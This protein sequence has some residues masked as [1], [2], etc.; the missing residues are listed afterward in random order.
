MVC[1][2]DIEIKLRKAHLIKSHQ[3]HSIKSEVHLPI[4][5]PKHPSTIGT[6]RCQCLFFHDLR[7]AEVRCWLRLGIGNQLNQHLSKNDGRFFSNAWVSKRM[8]WQFFGG[9]GIF[10]RVCWCCEAFSFLHILGWLR[11]TGH[12]PE[13]NLIPMEVMNLIWEAPLERWN[14]F[15]L[16]N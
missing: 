15:L 11:T 8:N 1:W 5:Q 12:H 13:V 16:I 3:I 9:L 14:I 10:F 2:F 6:P 7:L 4:K